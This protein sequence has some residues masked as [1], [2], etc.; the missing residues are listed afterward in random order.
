CRHVGSTPMSE[1]GNIIR[2]PVRGSRHEVGRGVGIQTDEAMGDAVQ[3]AV[4]WLSSNPGADYLDAAFAIAQRSPSGGIGYG[5]WPEFVGRVRTAL[6]LQ[7]AKPEA[8][9]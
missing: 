8:E 7:R 1:P 9:P 4:D 3:Q 5:W 6:E 2:F